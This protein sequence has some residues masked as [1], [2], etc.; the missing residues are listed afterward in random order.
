MST[1]P[2]VAPDR[3]TLNYDELAPWRRDNP[4]ILTGYRRETKSWRGCAESV[5]WL[6]NETGERT[7]GV[8]NLMR[9]MVSGFDF[10]TRHSE[11]LDTPHR[12]YHLNLIT[13]GRLVVNSYL[14]W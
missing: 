5:W 8:Q 10:S 14:A 13:L 12:G 7:R 1:T 4:A 6:H 11:H 2:L 9:P 3:K